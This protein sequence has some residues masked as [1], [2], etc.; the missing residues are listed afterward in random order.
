MLPSLFCLA[1]TLLRRGYLGILWTMGGIFTWG[2]YG[3][4]GGIFGIIVD[5]IRARTIHNYPKY[6]SL[7]SIISPSKYP[8]PLIII[9][10]SSL[11]GGELCI[12][13]QLTTSTAKIWLLQEKIIKKSVTSKY[14][15]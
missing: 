5:L 13:L 8:S 3:Q 11:C 9:S 15:V 10:P 12:P 6:S 7:L 1:L 2:Y 14:C 4:W